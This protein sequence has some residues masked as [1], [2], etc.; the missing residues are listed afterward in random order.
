MVSPED[1]DILETQ[2]EACLELGQDFKTRM[3]LERDNPSPVVFIIQTPTMFEFNVKDK[4]ET[5]GVRSY[6]FP[7]RSGVYRKTDNDIWIGEIETYSKGDLSNPSALYLSTNR[8]NDDGDFTLMSNQLLYVLDFEGKRVLRNTYGIAN[9]FSAMNATM[10]FGPEVQNRH[11]Y[12]PDLDESTLVRILLEDGLTSLS[13]RRDL[14]SYSKNLS[15]KGRNLRFLDIM[16][17][18]S[19]TR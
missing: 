10:F 4:Q 5:V 9:P 15:R 2:T 14:R 19:R 7:F 8:M 12:D 1:L 18:F 3:I 17:R 6:M 11:Y 13:H 16:S